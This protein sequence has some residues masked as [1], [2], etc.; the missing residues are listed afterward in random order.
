MSSM[1]Q[2]VGYGMIAIAGTIFTY[3]TIWVVV[4]VSFY[5]KKIIFPLY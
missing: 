2:A 5:L 4:L 1:D 3:Y